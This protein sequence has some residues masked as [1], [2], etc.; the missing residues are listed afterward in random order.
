MLDRKE[1]VMLFYR[2]EMVRKQ[3]QKEIKETALTGIRDKAKQEK[4]L[5]TTLRSLKEA[6]RT[7]AVRGKVQRIKQLKARTLSKRDEQDFVQ[8]NNFVM[9]QQLK[10][11]IMR[12]RMKEAE[13]R[14]EDFLTK[15]PSLEHSSKV[16]PSIPSRR[17]SKRKAR[18]EAEEP[19]V[20]ESPSQT[21]GE[22]GSVVN[23]GDNRRRGRK[24]RAQS[25][26]AY[27]RDPSFVHGV[28][29]EEY[30]PIESRGTS[31]YFPPVI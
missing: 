18:L 10:M 26:G 7:E 24:S 13:G 31:F 6:Q 8:Q 22:E 30:Y 23:R 25:I 17:S 1:K 20:E 9:E 15:K 28:F 5:N 16:V 12:G 27:M 3:A 2:E 4:I 21:I 11:V 14:R 29:P 19:S